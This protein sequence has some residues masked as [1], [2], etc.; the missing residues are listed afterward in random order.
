[1]VGINKKANYTDSFFLDKN[2]NGLG[3]FS[4]H[5]DF[6]YYELPISVVLYLLLSFVFKMLFNYRI[7]KYIRKY[8]FYGILLF[9]VC[10]GNIE[11]FAFYFFSECR[12]LFSVNFSHKMANVLMIYFFFFV[13]LFAVGGMLWIFYHYRKLIKYFLEDSK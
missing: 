2:P 11:Q 5:L 8:S 9:I 7:S 12:N 1:M 10:E 4:N 13:I 6:F 3:F